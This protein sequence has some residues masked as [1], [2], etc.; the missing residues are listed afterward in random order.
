MAI[1]QCIEI[2]NPQNGYIHC[3]T[4]VVSQSPL[5]EFGITGQQSIGL[6]SFIVSILLLVKCY[7][8]AKKVLNSI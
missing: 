4:W 7:K 2:T 8:I 3:K 5:Q 6:T 1:Y